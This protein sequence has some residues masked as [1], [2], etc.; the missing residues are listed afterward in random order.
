MKVRSPDPYAS[1]TKQSERKK[2]FVL[3]INTIRLQKKADFQLIKDHQ[4]SL[5][6]TAGINPVLKCGMEV[7]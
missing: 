4:R 2:N 6:A 5:Q 3:C 7:S 1:T